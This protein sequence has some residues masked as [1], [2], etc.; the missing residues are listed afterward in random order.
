MQEATN[1]R[2]EALVAAALENQV[3]QVQ[4]PSDSCTFRCGYLALSSRSWLKL[5]LSGWPGAVGDAVDALLRADR[6]LVVG[7][8]VALAGEVGLEAPAVLADVAEGVVQVGQPGGSVSSAAMAAVL[9]AK[10]LRISSPLG[11]RT[12]AERGG[13]DRAVA[14]VQG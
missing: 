4:P 13:G 8:G 3:D 11:A 5:P 1:A 14:A 9:D 7:P 2:R 10:R 6:P 12:N